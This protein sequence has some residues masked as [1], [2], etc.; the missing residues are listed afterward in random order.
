MLWQTRALDYSWN[1]AV[2]ST[3]NG[4][5]LD[6][7][8]AT[9]TLTCIFFQTAW[10]VVNTGDACFFHS[11]R[12]IMFQASPCASQPGA[13]IPQS[14]WCNSP[15]FQIPES[16]K[17]FP[18]WPF[19]RKFL[20]LSTKIAPYFLHF[21]L[22]SFNLCAFSL[23]Y[24]FFLPPTPYFYHDAFRHHQTRTGRL[25]QQPTFLTCWTVIFEAGG[26]NPQQ[27]RH[28]LRDLCSACV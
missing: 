23:V 16:M 22:L 1:S 15:L 4:N 25:W 10:R 24:V 19:P 18:N 7:L 21:P 17:K 27:G 11:N 14:Q 12:R 26:S 6:F 20:H 9:L 8:S 13:S 3:T 2:I 5:A 28:F